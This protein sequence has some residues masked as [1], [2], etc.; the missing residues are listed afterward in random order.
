MSKKQKSFKVIRWILYIV[1]ALVLTITIASGWYIWRLI[2]QIAPEQSPEIKAI[3]QDFQIDWAGRMNVLILGC[4]ERDNV[5]LGTRSDTVI[6]ANIDLKEK[7]V[8]LMSIPR[9]TR[10]Y[11][12]DYGVWD[13]MNSTINPNYF[14]DGGVPLTLRT[15]EHLLQVPIRLYV[16]LDFISFQEIVDTIG[17]VMIDVER[18]MFYYDPTD[19]TLINLKKGYQCLD[20]DKALQY[21]RFRDFQ[22]DYSRDPQGRIHGRVTRQTNLIRALAKEASKVRNVMKINNII[23]TLVNRVE[24]NIDASE[25]LKIA[26]TFRDMDI[27]KQIKVLPFPGE[28]AW[29]NGISYIVTQE[30]E[31]EKIIQTELQESDQIVEE[32]EAEE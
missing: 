13:K 6:L 7:I 19:G 21:V 3:R 9:D 17:C 28:I 32:E 22:G 24:T 29:I 11:V 31:L 10:V 2:T 12:P 14:R 30:D 5:Y 4:D 1:L 20:G 16:V 15:A 8:R 27:D 26:I 18:D 23:H 25:L